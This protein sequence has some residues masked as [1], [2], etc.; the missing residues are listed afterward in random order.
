MER[1]AAAPA[2]RR[3]PVRSDYT[4]LLIRVEEIACAVA[5]DKN[6]YV[7]VGKEEHRTYFTLTQLETLLPPHRFFRIH[8]S[9]LVNLDMVE[10]LLFLGG[11][12]YEVRLSDHRHL[13]VG[14]TRYV[15][16]QRRLGLRPP[17]SS[18]GDA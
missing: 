1:A 3:L 16:L 8:D 18:R 14:R 4:V 7:C 17:P 11:H 15:A 10:E 6:V 13:P 5:R 2:L 9:Y 12:T